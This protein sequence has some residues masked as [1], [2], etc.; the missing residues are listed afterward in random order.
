M[1]EIFN[2]VTGFNLKYPNYNVKRRQNVQN[3]EWIEFEKK[4]NELPTVKLRTWVLYYRNNGN[5]I[6]TNSPDSE[7]NYRFYNDMIN[8][9]FSKSQLGSIWG[10]PL[11]DVNSSNWPAFNSCLS[12]NSDYSGNELM[13]YNISE[14]KN[15]IIL[16]FSG[17]NELGN[18]SFKDISNNI[19]GITNAFYVML[20]VKSSTE[21]ILDRH[22]NL[23]DGNNA[24]DIKKN[25]WASLVEYIYDC[26]IVAPRPLLDFTLDY[27]SYIEGSF[28]K[29]FGNSVFFNNK[30]YSLASCSNPN[31]YTNLLNISLLTGLGLDF[32]EINR[33]DTDGI[34]QTLS[35]PTK[36][37][38][39][40]W[41]TYLQI[42]ENFNDS[43]KI[44]IKIVKIVGGLNSINFTD[45]WGK[46]IY[47]GDKTLNVNWNL[48]NINSANRGWRWDLKIKTSGTSNI[49]SEG[50]ETDYELQTLIW[51]SLSS[52][53]K[54]SVRKIGLN[55]DKL[56]RFVT[57]FIDLKDINECVGGGYAV[58]KN[59]IDIGRKNYIPYYSRL[60]PNNKNTINLS[61]YSTFLNKQYLDASGVETEFDFSETPPKVVPTGTLS[62]YRTLSNLESYFKIYFKPLLSINNN[63]YI[64]IKYEFGEDLDSKI[65]FFRY[66]EMDGILDP[67]GKSSINAQRNKE[68]I[69]LKWDKNDII[70]NTNDIVTK[71]LIITD[72]ASGFSFHNSIFDISSNIY[73]KTE[74]INKYDISCNVFQF[75]FYSYKA[76]LPNTETNNLPYSI[77]TFD[78]Q[79][80]TPQQIDISYVPTNLIPYRYLNYKFYDNKN[81]E[82]VFFGETF[83]APYIFQLEEYLYNIRKI[84]T[85][86]PVKNSLIIQP[87]SSSILSEISI[88]ISS[89]LN[90][91]KNSSYSLFSDL[92]NLTEEEESTAFSDIIA[93]TSQISKP[94]IVNKNNINTL[95]LSNIDNVS[96]FEPNFTKT[97]N[98]FIPDYW[99]IP[100]KLNRLIATNRPEFY[101]FRNNWQEQIKSSMIVEI[102]SVLLKD[103]VNGAPFNNIKYILINSNKDSDEFTMVTENGLISNN[104]L[105]FNVVGADGLPDSSSLDKS[106]V[107]VQL[108]SISTGPFGQV[109][110][111]YI[112]NTNGS[113]GGIDKPN[114]NDQGN[115]LASELIEK[116]RQGNGPNNTNMAR[117]AKG[118]NGLYDIKLGCWNDGDLGIQ[119]AFFRGT[120]IIP[121]TIKVLLVDISSAIQ[122]NSGLDMI[123]DRND[124]ITIKWSGF[125]FSNDNTWNNS[126]G[127][128]GN[129]KWS[130]LRYNLASGNTR[131][132]HNDVVSFINNEYIYNDT[133]IRVYDKY[134]YTVS[135]R[136]EWN[137]I[138]ELLSNSEIPTLNVPGFTTEDIFVCKFNRFPYGRFNTTATNLKL[139]APLLMNNVG[140]VDQYGKN[141]GGG[142]CSDPDNPNLKLF[143]RT[144]RI[145]SSN[146]IY[147]NTT[148]QVTKKQTYVTLSKSRFRPTR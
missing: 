50:P 4:S 101:F 12:S 25:K 105:I 16:D 112:G 123:S 133:N 70:T 119:N 142:P 122:T 147:A 58:Y 141:A 56:K 85:E 24:N 107:I 21:K 45:E 51:Y 40:N 102:I 129:I 73:D 37:N 82:L 57:N 87:K 104:K 64:K 130:I 53:R 111:N 18:N 71:S 34:L 103:E 29:L 137:G 7:D 79:I 80:T 60:N 36:I 89:D 31:T 33:M 81:V 75:N 27:F 86:I 76:G 63:D 69:T 143:A 127:Q 9:P 47:I 54:V 26:D 22:Y 110:V 106:P 14:N 118:Y 77:L 66:N 121:E 72:I 46:A 1:T 136:Y 135:G 62:A 13:L 39:K 124:K 6:D 95:N 113:G 126:I 8:C 19:E 32:S 138:R 93:L 15:I 42:K 43:L 5:D 20:R 120:N 139:Y 65:T 99:I 59:I 94:T 108:Q 96:F 48:W 109:S 148:N 114:P 49:W 23:Y 100:E 84:I 88:N 97:N 67:I 117:N 44:G 116:L 90:D 91:I 61:E 30:S 52:P 10:F 17:Y 146:N 41:F 92:P 132:I 134:K 128:S 131:L 74:K 83:E 68:S 3:G 145:S 2:N 35:L 78:T 28:C 98:F 38:S 140:Q 144:T 115:F 125:Y 55:G 11:F